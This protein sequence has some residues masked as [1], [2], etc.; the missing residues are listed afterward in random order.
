MFYRQYP[1][2]WDPYSNYIIGSH[3]NTYLNSNYPN[4]YMHFGMSHFPTSQQHMQLGSMPH[5][6]MNMT[7]QPPL[8]PGQL[9]SQ[10]PIQP[11][12]HSLVSYFHDKDGNLDLNKMLSTVGQLSNTV[13]QVS[14]LFKQFGALLGKV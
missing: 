12:M 14:P 1:Y 9:Y 5:N 3:P 2:E 4:A 10:K 7:M 11:P 8:L 6:P 13:K